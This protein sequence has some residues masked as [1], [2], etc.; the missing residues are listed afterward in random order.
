MNN[1]TLP[2]K[3]VVAILLLNQLVTAEPPA[4][5]PSLNDSIAKVVDETGKVF[6]VEIP[7]SW[8]FENGT[9]GH[10]EGLATV[11]LLSVVGDPDLDQ[12][13]ARMAKKRKDATVSRDM[14]GGTPAKRI[15]F[16]DL[17]KGD[18]TYMW[19]GKKGKR[20]AILTLVVDDSQNPDELAAIRHDLVTS[21]QWR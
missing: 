3:V 1:W 13:A 9:W 20:C 11:I 4:L 5:G 2:A 10:P 21:F 7:D 14:L 17:D 6:S 8:T 15:Q 12:W 18:T 19:I 16:S